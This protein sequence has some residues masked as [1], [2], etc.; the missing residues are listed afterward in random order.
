VRGFAAV[1]REVMARRPWD[2]AMPARLTA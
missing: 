1:L 2:P